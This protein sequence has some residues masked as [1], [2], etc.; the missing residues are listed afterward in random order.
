MDKESKTFLTVVVTGVIALSFLVYFGCSRNFKYYG[1]SSL[2]NK[3]S[4]GLVEGKLIGRDTRVGNTDMKSSP[5]KLLLWFS[6]DKQLEGIIQITEI[7]LINA[8]NNMVVFRNDEIVKESIEKYSENF[9]AFFSFKGLELEY[10][11]ME[12]QLKFS[13]EQEGK[14]SKYDTT[15]YFKKDY[16]EY[17][18]FLSV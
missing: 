2:E 11:E 15:I 8:K 17:R 18:R 6:S 10:E 1:F 13:L 5:Y 14:S 4:W 7:I 12:L 16:K 3:F 9:T